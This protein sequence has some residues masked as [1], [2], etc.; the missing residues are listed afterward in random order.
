MAVDG[1]EASP[2]VQEEQR[3]AKRD[4]LKAVHP[5]PLI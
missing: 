2:R 4:E 1:E 3:R 5:P